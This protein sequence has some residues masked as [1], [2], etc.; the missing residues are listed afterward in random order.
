MHAT[1]SSSTDDVPPIKKKTEEE[2]V[3]FK[4]PHYR[5][6]RVETGTD[7]IPSSCV[8]EAASRPIYVTFDPDTPERRENLYI[9]QL[10]QK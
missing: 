8:D 5:P 10:Y 6:M 1:S 7:A 2:T 9:G 4:S 3:N